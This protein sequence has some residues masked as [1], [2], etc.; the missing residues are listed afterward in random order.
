MSIDN[1]LTFIIKLP[2]STFIILTLLFWFWIMLIARE[3]A[4]RYVWFYNQQIPSCAVPWQFTPE[5][6]IWRYYQCAQNVV[7]R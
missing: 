6:K 4:A 5:E 3:L 2:A 7:H 1:Y